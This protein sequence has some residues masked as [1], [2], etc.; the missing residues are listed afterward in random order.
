M[1]RLRPI[2]A[3]E[4]DRLPKRIISGIRRLLCNTGRIFPKCA[5]GNGA[6]DSRVELRFIVAQIRTVPPRRRWRPGLVREGEAKEI[7]GGN[8]SIP[9]TPRVAHTL[10]SS[11][12]SR[13]IRPWVIASCMAG[14]MCGHISLDTP[15]D[16]ETARGDCVCSAAFAC[17]ALAT[18]DATERKLPKGRQVVCLDTAFHRSMPE[19]ARTL[20]L[21]ASVRGLGIDDSD[22]MAF[23]GIDMAQMD[24]VP[25]R[26]VV[27]HLGNGAS[28]TAIRT[29]NRSIPAWD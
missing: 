18:I 5:I 27:A 11:D 3:R 4:F 17:A 19:V 13:M 23:T 8:S 26:L 29:V 21:S 2:V 28:I 7:G 6:L 22:F 9:V 16:R 24:S 20:A 1:D 25:E 10:A 14:P 12:T 15:D